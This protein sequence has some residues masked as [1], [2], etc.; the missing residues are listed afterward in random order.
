MLVRR[1]AV[2]RYSEL[3]ATTLVRKFPWTNLEL[4]EEQSF[5]DLRG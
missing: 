3:S 5:E 1:T 4:L 2:A